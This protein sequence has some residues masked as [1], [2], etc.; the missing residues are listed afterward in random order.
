M[1]LSLKYKNLFTKAFPSPTIMVAGEDKTDLLENT[2]LLVGSIGGSLH[3]LPPYFFFALFV[4]VCVC[5]CVHSLLK[6]LHSHQVLLPKPL[7]PFL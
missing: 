4:C 1:Q 2:R 3:P 7:R 6:L 5:V